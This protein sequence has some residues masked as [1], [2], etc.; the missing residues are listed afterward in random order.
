MCLFFYILR[1]YYL[2]NQAVCIE[3]TIAN[4]R[5]YAVSVNLIIAFRTIL[6]VGNTMKYT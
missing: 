3:Q 5:K 2:R 4:R 6:L 1:I